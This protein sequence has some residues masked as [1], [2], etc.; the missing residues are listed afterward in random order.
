MNL[1][2]LMIGSMVVSMVSCGFLRR[3]ALR[4]DIIDVPNDRSSH[5]VPTAR[6][7]G[8]SIVLTFILGL[9]G[10][11]AVGLV[12]WQVLLPILIGG[13]VIAIV[14]FVD[15]RGHINA[16]IRLCCHFIGAA[17]VVYA[18]N[19]LPMLSFFGYTV[20]FAV[21]GWILAI[22][23]TV[24]ILN[25]FN[26]MDGIDG[27][28]GVEAVTST[29]VM[30]AICYFGFD[31]PG[32][33]LLH[34]ILGFASLGFLVWNFP[35][36]KIF[37]GDA[38]SGFLGLMLSTMLLLSAHISQ[39]LFWGWLVMLGVFIVDASITLSRR[40][41]H[42]QKPHE[43][44]RSHAYQFASRR[45]GSHLKVT[46][47]VLIINL[48]WLAP[49]AYAISTAIIDGFLGLLV[50]YIPLVLLAFKHNAGRNEQDVLTD[51]R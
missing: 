18:A 47:A 3:Y 15:D 17:L 24:W 51:G 26:F 7:G 42:G 49:I 13:S 37:M 31:A 39:A 41:L 20:D 34:L 4:K 6:G 25:L 43:A 21:A 30:G 32:I 40:L 44:H 12:S 10:C 9:I 8:V 50:A 48:F 23:A 38:G 27:I 46:M 22:F 1:I 35:P 36:A 45:Y 5:T 29:L 28:A 14:G 2:V 11:G 33:T 19:G 16:G